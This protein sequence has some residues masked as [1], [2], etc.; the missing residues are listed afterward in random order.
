MNDGETKANHWRQML[1]I[2][3][4]PTPQNEMAE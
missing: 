2:G 1:N 3:F 4:A